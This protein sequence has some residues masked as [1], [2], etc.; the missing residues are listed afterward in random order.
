MDRIEVETKYIPPGDDSLPALVLQ[1]TCMQASYMLWIGTTT[2][3]PE[4]VQRAVDEGSLARDWACAMPPPNVSFGM[5][6]QGLLMV[7]C[8]H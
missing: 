1:M 7:T 4:N 3:G 6:I 2:G 5:G 8:S